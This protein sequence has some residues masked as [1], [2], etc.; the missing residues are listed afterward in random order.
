MSTLNRHDPSDIP[1]RVRTDLFASERRCRLLRALAA[2]G[3]EQS[4]R[5]LAVEIRAEETGQAADQV[6]S[7]TVESTRYEIYDSHLPKL[8]ATGVVE[9][10][11]TLDKLRL[12]DADLPE[13]AEP[14][15]D[16]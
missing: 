7:D 1:E 10:D 16:E 2:A 4:V 3:G 6:D 15:L 11:S 12:L 8:A 13:E 14:E 9:Y 5:D